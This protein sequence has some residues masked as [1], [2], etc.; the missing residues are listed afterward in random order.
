MEIFIVGTIFLFIHFLKE[1]FSLKMKR[2]IYSL[3]LFFLLIYTG[4]QDKN[5]N[6]FLLF[7]LFLN[8]SLLMSKVKSLLILES[9][10]VLL[11]SINIFGSTIVLKQLTIFGISLLFYFFMI[12]TEKNLKVSKELLLKKSRELNIIRKTSLLFQKSLDYD[13][14]I[15][16]LL[17]VLTSEENLNYD[18][19]ILFLYDDR[20]NEFLPWY[21]KTKGNSQKILLISKEEDNNEL[22]KMKIPN[23]ILNPFGKCFDTKEPITINAI[24]YN[25]I[26]Q[27]KIK[28]TL[29]LDRF[30]LLPLIE[31]NN[32]KGIILVDNYKSKQSIESEDLDNAV[33]IIHQASTALVNSSLYKQSQNMAYTDGLTG[34][35]NKRFLD[36]S[37]DQ[38]LAKLLNQESSL[39]LFIIDVDYFKKFNDTN[40]HI[41][42]NAALKKIADLLLSETRNK[43]IVARFGGEEFCI[44]LFDVDGVNANNVAERMRTKIEKENFLHG[45]NVPEGKLTISIGIT[46]F[47]GE[48]SLEELVEKADKAL[49]MAKG[50][51]R[52]RVEMERGDNYA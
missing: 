19:A 5:L 3:F 29:T 51:G 11:I 49:Y 42:G 34:L 30:G 48:Q 38:N 10:I 20:V 18:R 52:N 9:L 16:V 50:S 37:F 44:L 21:L 14:I 25:D 24:D 2:V 46:I 36:F 32:I 7:S 41:A 23:S 45:K 6:L 15:D 40:G 47:S 28:K 12:K 26:V 31:K 4:F 27:D 22:K 35:Y 8:I 13:E 43:D 17:G 39:A 1:F 33:S